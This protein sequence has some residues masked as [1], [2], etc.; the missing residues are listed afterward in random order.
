MP[1][2]SAIGM[3]D[4]LP[5]KEVTEQGHVFRHKCSYGMTGGDAAAGWPPRARGAALLG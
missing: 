1:F 3:S 2:T 4:P 5:V